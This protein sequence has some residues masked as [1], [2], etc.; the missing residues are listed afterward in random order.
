MG[1]PPVRADRIRRYVV[2]FCP[3]CHE[4]NP[5]LPLQEVA[6]LS[7]YLS[8]QDGRVW[9]VRG[10]PKHGRIATL[11][12]QD[13]AILDYLE[14]WTAPTK[15]H[16]PDTPGNFDPVPAC[17][18]RGLGE[19][20][21]QHTCILLADVT[22][23]CDLRCPTCFASGSPDLEGFADV[24]EVLAAVDRRISLEDGYLDVLMVSGGEPTL[25][26]KLTD[27]LERAMERNITRILLNTNGISI[28]RD[29]ALLSFLERHNQRLEVY[30]QHD[31]FREA[32]HRFHR[33]GDLRD[34]KQ[35][36]LGRLSDAGVFT[37]LVMTARAGVNDDEIGDVVR[38]AL[39]TAFVGGLCI[40]PA[41]G[42]GRGA[43]IDS[44][45]RLTSTGVLRRLGPQTSDVIT[46]RDLTALPCSH[47]HCAAVGYMFRMDDG[48]W[49]SLTGLIGHDQLKAN[50]GLVS[51]RMLDPDLSDELQ[52]LAKESLM[53]LL[54]E[55]SSLTHP[56]IRRMLSVVDGA[57]DLGMGGL[58]RRAGS[59]L[60]GRRKLREMLARRVKR[61]TVK[62]F[63]DLDT[64]IEERLLQCCVHVATTGSCGPQAI[65]FCAAQAWPGLGAMK[66]GTA[67][68]PA[69]RQATVL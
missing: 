5:A 52:T 29:D 16:T 36:A 22:D 6:R 1:G 7:G 58:L 68:G 19:M 45:D 62:P 8:E 64:M 49:R 42:S 56:A 50:L 33:G 30:L 34:I 61:I 53:G 20:Q 51:N 11:Y 28:A 66:F 25:H 15:R 26:P 46:W 27:L 12:Q 43:R 10:C 38:L 23:S 3:R 32:T 13:A 48:A 35:R 55:Q 39:D 41:F 40:Q 60:G 14:E 37:T 63:M 2:A 67:A 21:T 31:G 57:C 65:P 9:L 54:S 47:P 17:Y 69:L 18:A 59:A 44:G 24:S 4:E